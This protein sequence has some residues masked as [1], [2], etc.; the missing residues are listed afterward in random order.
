M[1]PTRRHL[2][3]TAGAGGLVGALALL[4][5][6]LAAAAPELEDD[7]FEELASRWV[8]QLTGRHLLVPGQARFDDL[9]ED[10]DSDA[11]EFL[12]Q[13]NPAGSATVFAD[14]D[15]D[16]DPNLTTTVQRLAHLATA[17]ATPG[18]RHHDDATLRDLVIVGLRDFRSRIYNP[19]QPEYGNWWTWEIGV[20]RALAD[21]MAILREHLADEDV[22]A[23]GDSIDFYVPDPWEQFPEER[24][25][26]TSEGANRV[27]LCQAVII[28]SIVG[29]DR[30]RLA[31]AIAGL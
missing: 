31:H 23:F 5:P 12:D 10:I 28:R 9:I 15:Y 27:D 3:H 6:D 19:S 1:Q 18:S 30:E 24:G 25:R 13:L 14:L 17:W 4:A 20:T 26:I 29:R 8:D 7:G 21:A 2:L 11:D 22:A 16:A